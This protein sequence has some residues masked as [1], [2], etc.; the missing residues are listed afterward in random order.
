[1]HQ[2]CRRRRRMLAISIPFFMFICL[3]CRLNLSWLLLCRCAHIKL[4]RFFVIYLFIHSHTHTHR[5]TLNARAWSRR[6]VFYRYFCLFCRLIFFLFLSFFCMK[7]GEQQKF[8]WIILCFVHRWSEKII[9]NDRVILGI[10]MCVS[11][12]NIDNIFALSYW[13][14]SFRLTSIFP[15]FFS[16]LCF[17]FQRCFWSDDKPCEWLDSVNCAVQRSWHKRHRCKILRGIQRSWE[18]RMR[19]V[20]IGTA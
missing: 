16:L 17:S 9:L 2:N 11:I 13:F 10:L 1:M 12:I 18:Q 7:R 5:H 6:V 15:W 20:S 4:D 3:S 14:L 8:L 19:T